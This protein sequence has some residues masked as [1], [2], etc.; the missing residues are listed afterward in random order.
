VNNGGTIVLDVGKTNS[1][2]SVWDT[3]GRL[4]ARRDRANEPQHASGYRALD[5]WGIDEWLM[6]T[7]REFAQQLTVSRIMTVGHGAAAV[8]L[9]EGRLWAPPMDYEHE[10]SAADRADYAQQRD[11]FAETGSPGLPCGLNLGLQLH[12]LE[13]VC[14]PLPPDV[15]IVPWPQYW[16]WRLCGVAASEVSSLGCHTDLWQPRAHSFSTLAVRRG[17]AARMAPLRLAGEQLGTITAYI[18]ERTGLSPDCMVLC[19]MHDSNAALLSAAGHA[20]IAGYDATILSTGTWFVALRSLQDGA[21]IDPEALDDSRDCLI[22]VDVFGRPVPSARFMGGR[23]AELIGGVDSFAVTRNYEP[24]MLLARLP[25]LI[26]NGSSVYPSFVRGVGPFPDSMGEWCNQPSDP[27]DQRA[28]TELYLALMA[29]TALDLIGS[30]ERL[31]IEGRFAEATLFVRSLAA[32]RRQHRV[33]V[34][35][36]HQDVAYGALRLMDPDLLPS[37]ELKPVEPLD[38]DLTGYAALWR[39]RA[40]G[41]QYAS[42]KAPQR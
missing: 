39:A 11:P 29:S 9:Q 30:R 7:L 18:A 10:V 35:N 12:H 17:W 26:A 19:G 16:A 23:E 28:I 31:L 36:A 32:L 13:R 2:A 33:F 27:R 22:N 1:K 3:S 38:L 4:L 24:E 8:L 34:S 15:T 20:E 5:V 14:G 21:S 40:H 41:R 37:C 6:N 42:R 25:A